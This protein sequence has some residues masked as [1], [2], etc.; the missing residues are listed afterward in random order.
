MAEINAFL[1]AVEP[2]LIEKLATIDP[3]TSAIAT[4]LAVEDGAALTFSDVADSDGPSHELLDAA[5]SKGA[6]AA[7]YLTYVP[8]RP[9][10]VEAKL[11]VKDPLNSDIR[12]TYVAR[13]PNTAPSLSSWEYKL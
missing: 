6:I 1:A 8:N 7:A 5:I 4:W 2:H 10:R 13:P 9:E 11:L 12:W 3:A